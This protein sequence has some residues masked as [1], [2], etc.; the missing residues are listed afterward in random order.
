MVVVFLVVV[1]IVPQM[2]SFALRFAIVPLNLGLEVRMLASLTM[3]VSRDGVLVIS[4]LIAKLP[5]LLLGHSTVL[6]VFP[7]RMVPMMVTGGS[8]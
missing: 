2:D 6:I 3:L 8:A 1:V 4:S 7:M 5:S